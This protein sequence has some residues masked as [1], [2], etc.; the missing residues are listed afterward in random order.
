MSTLSF[1]QKIWKV[2]Y[3]T[4]T[5]PPF[6]L[7]K[8]P[9]PSHP[10]DEHVHEPS[11]VVIIRG[12]DGSSRWY[13]NKGLAPGV[14]RQLTR[15]EVS[16]VGSDER[17]R[18]E[19]AWAYKRPDDESLAA[20]MAALEVDDPLCESASGRNRTRGQMS[21]IEQNRNLAREILEQHEDQETIERW[22]ELKN[23]VGPAHRRKLEAIERQIDDECATMLM[24]EMF[25]MQ[26]GDDRDT[27]ISKL[28]ETTRLALEKAR[29]DRSYGG[30][31]V[32][33]VFSAAD[34]RMPRI[35]LAQ[36]L[37]EIILGAGLKAC[38]LSE[39]LHPHMTFLQV[40][41]FQ[42]RVAEGCRDNPDC[43]FFVTCD[44]RDCVNSIEAILHIDDEIKSGAFMSG[45]RYHGDAQGIAWRG[46]DFVR[47]AGVG[48]VMPVEA[49][50]QH[51]KT[52]TEPDRE[53]C[54]CFE[55]LNDLPASGFVDGALTSACHFTC[56]HSIC[57]ACYQQARDKEGHST[58]AQ[59]PLCRSKN[60]MEKALRSAYPREMLQSRP[61]GKS[62][63]QA[64]SAR[65]R[66]R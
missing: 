1:G 15:R 64:R 43:I 16:N 4:W 27:S 35:N 33:Q 23:A 66:N 19:C 20:L 26:I 8:A 63:K 50:D 3:S 42:L 56:M 51:M 37:H 9:E 11:D 59:C 24:R 13:T 12:A 52:L 48:T 30:K 39:S 58:M 29:K 25:E 41:E 53:C 62:K 28:V 61:S 60:S 17:R 45:V 40:K 6:S 32:G 65:R 55:R 2:P 14:L 22:E 7:P 31:V 34:Y 18:E 54:I 21:L 38:D 36:K 46:E 47:F 5:S 44:S 49:L 10:Y 57:R